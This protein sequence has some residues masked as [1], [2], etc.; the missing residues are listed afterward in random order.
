ML[1]A[2]I[3][4]DE[5]QARSALRAEIKFHCEDLQVIGEAGSVEEG[6]NLLTRVKT[7]LVFLDIQLTDGVGFEILEGLEKINFKV[8]FTTAYS[9][10]ALKAFRFDALDYLLKPIDGTELKEAVAKVSLSQ[11]EDN[12][13]KLENFF[14]NQALR[15]PYKRI[16]LQT[17][18]GIHLIELRT[19][20]RLNSEGNYTRFYFKD[21]QKMMVGKTLK[22]FEQM[23]TP[24]GFER[25]HLSHII[26]LSHLK[27]YISKD[28]GYVVLSDDSNVPVSQ[29]KKSKL[30]EVLNGFNSI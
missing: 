10:Y 16:A 23:L 25:V 5:K 17:S 13:P 14:R 3:I 18:D 29:R 11:T 26:N 24:F 8:I 9:E 21:G 4:D 30:I 19:I 7:D 20:I 22:D 6:L 28:G 12:N 27:S 1:R 2:I 15:D